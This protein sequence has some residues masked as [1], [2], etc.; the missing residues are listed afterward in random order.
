MG[1]PVKTP[2]QLRPILIGFRKAAGLTQA[3]VASRLGITQQTYAQLEAKPESASMDR[4][5][6]VLKVLKVDIVLT[7]LLTPADLEDRPSARLRTAKAP[8]AAKQSVTKK[9]ATPSAAK[10]PGTRKAAATPARASTQRTPKPL[11][12]KRAASTAATPRKRE[13][14]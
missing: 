4:L 14:W 11:A 13:D 3:Q 2:H 5:F 12:R 9:R 6:Q 1:Y 10:T 7:Q 8:A